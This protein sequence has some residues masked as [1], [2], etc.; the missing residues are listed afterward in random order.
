M[1]KTKQLCL[2][3]LSISFLAAG[4]LVFPGCSSSSSSI[5][6]AHA[7]KAEH[8]NPADGKTRFQKDSEENDLAEK[9]LSSQ[10]DSL[11]DN[12]T[13]DEFD[14]DF[15]ENQ[16]VNVEYIINRFSKNSAGSSSKGSTEEKL[17]M[18][19]I[20]Y[21]KTPYKYGGNSMYGIDCSAFTQAV[22]KNTFSFPLLRSAREQ[23]T[24]GSMI[25]DRTGLKFGD[26][27]FFNTRRRVRPGHVGIY[28]GDNFF[29]HAS[30]KY[31]V[32]ISSL[33]EDYYARK[34]MG[35]RR[36]EDFFSKN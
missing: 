22:Y 25:D 4:I 28:I 15:T 9:S 32:R 35:G 11:N 18:E 6:Y 19:I 26:L 36:I 33:D 20:K 29:A 10:P 34:F 3:L 23:Y 5:R 12:V 14:E 17:L 21:L 30:S 24:Q 27:V 16:T 2:W 8:K 31:G 13:Q 7:T 1:K